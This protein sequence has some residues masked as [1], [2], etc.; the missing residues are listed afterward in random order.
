MRKTSQVKTTDLPTLFPLI[1]KESESSAE[2]IILD[3][4][5]KFPPL[6]PVLRYYDDFDDKV[7]TIKTYVSWTYSPFQRRQQRLSAIKRL[8]E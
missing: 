3:I 1:T 2:S 4:I 5:L 7:R 6:P 8:G